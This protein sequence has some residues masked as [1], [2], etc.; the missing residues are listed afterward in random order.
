MTVTSLLGRLGVGFQGLAALLAMLL[1]V[2]G[3]AYAQ[4]PTSVNPTASSVKEQ[5]LLDALKGSRD[6]T[7][8]VAGRISIPDQRAR[9]LIQ[10][11]GQDFR[12]THQ[13]TL[14]RVGMAAIIGMLVLLLFFFIRRGRIRV[15]SGLSGT[16]VVRFGSFER[17]NHWMT[18]VSFILLALTGLNLTFG[19]SFV[20][21]L[22]GAE[23]FA[24]LTQLG[25]FVHN[26]VSFAFA[27]G[28][29]LMF[30][31]WIKD[32]LPLPRDVKWLAQGGGLIGNQHPP[33]GRFNGGQK[34]L[35]WAVIL[36]GGGLAYTGYHLMFPFQFADV[37]GLQWYGVL[38]GLIGVVMV[39]II[40]GH[41]YIGS[42]GMQGAF[43]AMGS[44]KVDVNWAREHHSIWADKVIT[45]APPAGKSASA[46]PQPAE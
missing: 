18:A 30:L 20:L 21:P 44:G 3:G 46:K 17:F 32:N 33:A 22:V 36:G 9:N 38:H 8:A 7:P 23:K 28:I 35:F 31:L 15:S 2:A 4:Q 37:G 12:Y 16:S 29:A 6:A 24:S 34:I 25:K 41:I 43:S 39:A 5:Q 1:V 19:K 26:Y 40:L 11:A 10:P 45:R 42:L 14:P 13:V 27:L